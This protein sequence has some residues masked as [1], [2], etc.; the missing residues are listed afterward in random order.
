[1]DR[2]I[3]QSDLINAETL[4][5][6]TLCVI[7]VGAIGR[8]VALQLAAIGASKIKLVDPDT[9]EDINIATQGYR[10]EHIGKTKVECTAADMRG[11]NDN[12]ELLEVIPEKFR[13]TQL[14]QCT[15]V[16]SCV[17][18]ISV[19]TNI[20]NR[21]KLFDTPFFVDGR[22]LGEVL[23]VLTIYDADSNKYYESTLFAQE[24][25]Q[26]GRCTA[27]STIYTAN[28][29]AGFML[30]SFTKYLRKMPIDYDVLFNIAAMD[31]TKLA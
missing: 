22:M 12:I 26:D 1:M 15:G 9:V 11:I 14:E 21:I 2:F 24:E 6:Q 10:F 19:R 20:Y 18:K 5:Q 28:I 7:G 23:R 13:Y 27:R 17:D 8:Q 25:Q 29:A 31:L 3:R 30:T 4:A 16:F